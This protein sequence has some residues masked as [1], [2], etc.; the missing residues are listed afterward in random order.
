M[1][2]I[3]GQLEKCPRLIIL[4]SSL[5]RGVSLRCPHSLKA[6]MTI[7]SLG[8]GF[9]KGGIPSFEA[10]VSPPNEAFD[11]KVEDYIIG[12]I[13][14]NVLE[15]IPSLE[16]DWQSYHF[17]TK[18]GPKGPAM[19]SSIADLA[20]LPQSLRD[21]IET[22]G[23]RELT[24]RLA[25]LDM[26]LRGPIG[27]WAV[28]RGIKKGREDWL[29]A[30]SI[31]SDRELK[32]RPFAILDYWSQSACKRLHDEIFSHLKGFKTDFTFRQLEAIPYLQ[33]IKPSNHYW[34]L[35]L[36]SATDR[37]P[38]STQTK[39]LALFIGEAKA[40]AW[41]DIMVG[42][43]FKLTSSNHPDILYQCG[44]PM[45]AYSSWA[46]FTLLHH[47]LVR[48][49]AD[50]IG[51]KRY[52]LLGDDIVVCDDEVAERLKM[53]YHSLGVEV[54][55]SKTM[56]SK[57]TFEF[58]KRLITKGEDVSPYPIMGL[59]EVYK[60]PTLLFLWTIYEGESRGHPNLGYSTQLV[61]DLY[62]RLG[63]PPRVRSMLLKHWKLA[64]SYPLLKL[65]SGYQSEYD[66]LTLAGLS[67]PCR[68]N[69][70]W[71]RKFTEECVATM[72]ANLILDSFKEAQARQVAMFQP[73]A[74][75]K[76]GGP[77][78]T[79][80]EDIM[81]YPVFGANYGLLQ[82]YQDI[83]LNIRTLAREQSFDAIL[84]DRVAPHIADTS[85]IL[86]GN[87]TQILVGAVGRL[88]RR[89]SELIKNIDQTRNDQLATADLPADYE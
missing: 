16:T 39:M 60:V 88:I 86:E 55:L 11:V 61:D 27:Q 28:T 68:T 33:E 66:F 38:I 70:L 57:D 23:G 79:D 44:Q 72:Y 7:L 20:S 45:G 6:A 12:W 35:D 56:V 15:H 64:R 49:A 47:F 48:V 81:I 43:P 37:M 22:L 1:M 14:D 3:S 19:L 83:L 36:T 74:L 32:L 25:M 8:R 42:Y 5:Q 41:R 26:W 63:K 46:V 62:T 29:R 31:R 50:N 24:T 82:D 76:W 80:V 67:V 78:I 34:S 87:R 2:F 52:A 75:E 53:L 54:N 85:R 84:A 40:E 30:I 51:Y 17:S 77:T 73:S 71:L 13:K 4:P 9:R 58:A 69:Q 65:S 10:I 59:A 18:A 21:S 89:S